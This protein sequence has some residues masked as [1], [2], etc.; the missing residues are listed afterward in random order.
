M[1]HGM[2]RRADPCVQEVL[3]G[4]YTILL[5]PILYGV[6]NSKGGSMRRGELPNS[7]A[8][9]LQQCGQCRWAGEIK[10]WLIRAQQPRS[11][12]YIV[13]AKPPSAPPADCR[14]ALATRSRDAAWN[15]LSSRSL[16]TRKRCCLAL[17][18]ILSSLYLRTFPGTHNPGSR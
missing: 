1:Q 5:L 4:F 8:V 2:S 18:K 11:K 16:C 13:K 14:L 17:K 7:R 10:R 6:W 9:V 15:E 3:L 12:R